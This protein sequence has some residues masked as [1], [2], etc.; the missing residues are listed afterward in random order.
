M[1]WCS[2]ITFSEQKAKNEDEEGQGVIMYYRAIAGKGNAMIMV[3]WGVKREEKGVLLPSLFMCFSFSFLVSYCSFFIG[4]FFFLCH[5]S[6]SIC[7]VG[8]PM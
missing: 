1:G 8:V 6:S 5:F 3:G 2:G 7:C 4:L